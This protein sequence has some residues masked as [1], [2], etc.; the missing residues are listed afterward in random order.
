MKWLFSKFKQCDSNI[1]YKNIKNL[2]GHK[3][4]INL[5]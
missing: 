5:N 3:F 4:K 2:L 1:L